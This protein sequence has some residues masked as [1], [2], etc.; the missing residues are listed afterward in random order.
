M[1]E[2]VKKRPGFM[3]RLLFFLKFLEI[4]LRFVMILVVTALAVGYWDHIQNYYERWQRER[5]GSEHAGHT[6]TEMQSD[7]EYYCG[8]HP[9]VVRDRP[10][11]CP[12]CGMDLTPRK[13]GAPVT[14][15]EGTLARVQASPERV[16]QAGV[17]AE[18]VLYRMLSRTVE[19]YGAVEV[20]E[21]RLTD[22]VARFPGRVE[23]LAVNTT[24]QY[25]EQGHTLARIYSPEF[26]AGSDEYRRALAAYERINGVPSVSAAEKERALR[27]VEGARRRL[28]LAGFTED[29]LAA[30]GKGTTPKNE[31]TLYSPVSG[32]VMEKNVIEGQTVEEGT[33]L[34]R[35]ADLSTLWVQVQVLES[36]ISAVR[37]G[38]PVEVTSVTWPGEIF[39]GTADFVYPEVNPEN[40]SVKVRVVVKNHEGKLKPGMYANAV[41]RAPM[42]QYGPPGKLDLLKAATATPAPPADAPPPKLPTT[43]PEDAQRYLASLEE[44]AGYYTCTMHPEVVSDRPGDCPKC[45]M[46]L[47][48]EK[49]G[50][51]AAQTPA[52]APPPSLPTTTPAQAEAFLATVPAGGKYYTCTMDPQ[53]VSDKPGECP[54]CGMKL[55][56]ATKPADVEG[57]GGG[58]YERWA[59]GYACGMHPDEL[60]EK[61]GKCTICGCG[62]EMTQWEVERVLSIPESAVIDTGA[63][64]IVYVEAE[65]GLYDARQVELGPRSGNYYPVLAGLTLGQ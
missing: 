2:E 33:V 6:E 55:T 18:P 35:I 20:D 62:M 30:V 38:M 15:P 44:G 47:V 22:M 58:S 57:P 65:P 36:D 10:G 43:T 41:I 37:I 51:P 26:L 32:T 4:R 23:D 31:V 21:T 54:L 11:K 3:K 40:R 24:G 9:F 42:G 60:S 63:R 5:A 16:M 34:Y 39:Y 64:K 29:Q 7:I 46:K 45:G 14:L 13:K 56:P 1:S 17:R 25:V 8:M 50:A 52:A 19:S 53:V 49:K 61:P 27:L 59:E 28:Q 12:I 48:E